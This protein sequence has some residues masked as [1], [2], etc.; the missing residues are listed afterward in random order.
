M[1]EKRLN[2]MVDDLYL[3]FPLFRKKILKHKRKLNKEKMPRSYYH[4]LGVLKKRGCLQMSEIGRLVHI[5][6]SNMTSLID[7]LVADGL[8]E[9]LPDKNDRRVINI[10]ITDKGKELL[11]DWRK[12]SNNEIKKNLSTLSDADLEKFYDSVENITDILKKMD[13][14]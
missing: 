14:D 2:K 3:F 12:Y 13:N 4:V 11:R 6:K 8:A 10:A 7:K 1:D 5:S 9:R